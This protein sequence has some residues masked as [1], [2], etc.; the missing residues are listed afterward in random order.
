MKGGD[1]VQNSG[2]T[3][4]AIIDATFKLA[5]TKPI[6]R[7][8]VHDIADMC[9][10]TRNAFYYHFR[11]IYDV[12]GTA[13]RDEH[14]RISKLIA[15]NDYDGIIYDIASFVVSNKKV[16]RNLYKVMGRDKLTSV[17]VDRLHGIVSDYILAES[18]GLNVTSDD[19]DI[20]AVFYEEALLGVL[21]RWLNNDM[22]GNLTD[23][24]ERIQIIFDGQVRAA[25][26]NSANSVKPDAKTDKI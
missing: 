15:A 17:I 12:L 4:Q 23:V 25:L 7:I 26:K 19:A 13:F 24:V 21:F 10:I 16:L 22:P 20:I 8:T 1:H 2:D 9:G 5:Q 3:K 14:D 18:K 6:N 11:D